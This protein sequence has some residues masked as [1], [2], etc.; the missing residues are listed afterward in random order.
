[1]YHLKNNLNEWFYKMHAENSD[2]NALSLRNELLNRNFYYKGVG[3]D[4]IKIVT[5][6][7]KCFLKNNIVK[8]NKRE[9]TNIIVFKEPKTRYVGDLTNI[10]NELLTKTK[11]IYQFTI[12]D[13][14]SKFLNSY[15]LENKKA[16][17]ILKCLNHFFLYFGKP[18]E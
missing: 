15:L 12:I 17:S 5:Q 7:S 10:P 2:R 9:K 6:C 1:M 3:E 16:N 13:H 14:F 11:Y 8:K 4:T 18:K